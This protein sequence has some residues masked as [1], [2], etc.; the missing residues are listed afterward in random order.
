M[1]AAVP[2]QLARARQVQALGRG[3]GG[4]EVERI[5]ATLKSYKHC[6]GGSNRVAHNKARRLKG[7]S[8]RGA[9]LLKLV[10]DDHAM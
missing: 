4:A 5:K 7:L 3:G 6:C 1:Q 9:R 10:L 2:L 8:N